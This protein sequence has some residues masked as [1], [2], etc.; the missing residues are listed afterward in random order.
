MFLHVYKQVY[1]RIFY[2]FALMEVFDEL[3]VEGFLCIPW[4]FLVKQLC[5]L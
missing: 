2:T 3:I 5:H 4:D 1:K